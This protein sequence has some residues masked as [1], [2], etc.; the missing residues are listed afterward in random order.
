MMASR[1]YRCAGSAA[2]DRPLG[3]RHNETTDL[4][5]VQGTPVK[6]THRFILLYALPAELPAKNGFMARLFA[7]GCNDALVGLGR[8]GFASL[9]FDREATDRDHAVRTA[10]QAVSLVWPDAHLVEVRHSTA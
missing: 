4:R 9:E 10:Q 8:P 3:S 5:W 1:T 7:A 6:A 2:Q